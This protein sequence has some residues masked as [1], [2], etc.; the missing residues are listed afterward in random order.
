[1][2]KLPRKCTIEIPVFKLQQQKDKIINFK[3]PLNFPF[4]LLFEINNTK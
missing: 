1:M 2:Q 4:D 3:F